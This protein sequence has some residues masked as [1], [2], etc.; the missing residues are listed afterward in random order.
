MPQRC[1]IASDLHKCDAHSGGRPIAWHFP[2]WSWSRSTQQI[3]SLADLRGERKRARVYH[4]RFHSHNYSAWSELCMYD[5]RSWSSSP[6]TQI[7]FRTSTG[8]SICG[9][10]GTKNYHTL[11]STRSNPDALIAPGSAARCKPP[12]GAPCCQKVDPPLC[13]L[14]M[15]GTQ[16]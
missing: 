3:T 6:L 5:P 13:S 4:P 11:V 16:V 12:T 15:S 8:S 14:G 1:S 7:D 2:D 10:S 9:Q